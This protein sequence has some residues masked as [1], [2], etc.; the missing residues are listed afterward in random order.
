MS[1]KPTKRTAT[2]PLDRETELW[3]IERARELGVHPA[4]VAAAILHD[5]RVDDE[6]AHKTTLH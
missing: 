6:A 2:L 5:V 4:T 1:A 3:L